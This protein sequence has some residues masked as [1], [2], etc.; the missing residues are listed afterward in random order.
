MDDRPLPNPQTSYGIQ[1]FIGEQLVAD[2][3]RKG[4]CA[5]AAMRLMT[6]SVRPGRP[7]AAA[8]GFMSGIIREPLAGQRAVCPVDPADRGGARLPARAIEALL[9]AAASPDEVWGGRTAVTMP[10]LTVTVGDMAAALEQVA[11]PAVT[12]SSTGSRTRWWR[13]WCRAGPPVSTRTG[14]PAWA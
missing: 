13:E 10:G 6:V 3:T 1:K 14:R 9:C 12:A 8:S 7:N 2:Y 11:G 4:S 5:A